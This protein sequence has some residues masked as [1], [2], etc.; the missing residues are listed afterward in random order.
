MHPLL[1]YY[2]QEAR[3]YAAVALAC[4]VGFL[5]FLDAVEGRRG[6]LGWAV[7]SAVA[8]GCHYFAIFP[9][10]IEAVILLARRGRAALPALAGVGVVGAGLLPLVLEQLGG[11]HSDNVTAGAAW[12]RA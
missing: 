11:G 5:C 4:A 2:S 3:G 9:V 7:A 10:A 8:L 6:A 12:R 1:V